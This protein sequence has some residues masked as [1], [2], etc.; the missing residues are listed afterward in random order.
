MSHWERQKRGFTLLEL[1]I[2]IAI[3]AVLAAIMYPVFAAARAKARQVQCVSNVT[4]IGIALK[5][6][7]DD[8]SG[9]LPSF[10]QS[11][12][13]FVNGLTDAEKQTALPG[14]VTWD[15]SIQDYLKS[16]DVLRCPDSPFS[17]SSRSVAIAAYVQRHEII[18]GTLY[19]LGERLGAIPY[20]S[21]VVL[22]FEK[23][24]N[25]PGAWGDAMGE[26]V[27]QSHGSSADV[28]YK[29][30][31]FHSGGKNIC[32]LDGHAKRFK[33]GTGPFANQPGGPAPPGSVSAEPGQCY[34]PAKKSRG[35]D[36][37]DPS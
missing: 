1:L 8:H 26:N 33:L 25:P 31:D 18:G 20:H 36:W 17:R 30:D 35:G 6:Y 19:F 34:W 23:G 5:L 16:T 22:L 4:Q 3:I 7:A 14:V 2:V 9:Y 13:S 15:V 28:G 29:T 27:W 32:F 37:P 11:H 24:A 10:S 12:P 21:H